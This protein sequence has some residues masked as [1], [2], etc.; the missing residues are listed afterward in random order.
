MIERAGSAE[1]AEEALRWILDILDEM[2]PGEV[3][4]FLLL[5]DDGM[6]LRV[7]TAKGLEPEFM[8][9]FERQVGGGVL[10]DVV[11]GGRVRGLR[12][13]DPSSEEYKQ[14]R[15]DRAFKSA[16]AAPAGAVGRSIGC[17][18]VQSER[19]DDYNLEHL[20][21]V[22][23][24]ANL[25]G[26]VVSHMRARSECARLQPLDA[27]TGLLRHV[28]FTK[29]LGEEIAR[30][31]RTRLPTS[32]LLVHL[33]GL[34]KLRAAGGREPADEVVREL[35]RIARSTLRGV[36][37]LG[38]ES[39]GRVEVCLPDTGA[40]AAVVA[41]R[42][43]L[44]EVDRFSGERWPEAGLRASVGV[45]TFPDDVDDARALLARASEAVVAARRAG[46]DHVVR[47][48]GKD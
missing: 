30:A 25:A 7:K 48:A 6:T 34:A 38:R 41:G 9:R 47:L 36:D 3:K 21:L 43:L 27:E 40:D 35:A 37:F 19:E 31:R 5:D 20:N 26:E 11:W 2:V 1:T 14:M 42:R 46:S 32:V 16:V 44:E 29:R 24:A 23:L 39:L 18:C 22:A 12:Q 15:L 13:V 10:A 17:L 33:D 4:A 8:G 28:Q 45:A